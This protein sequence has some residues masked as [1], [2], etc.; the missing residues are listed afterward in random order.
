MKRHYT[1]RL[2]QKAVLEYLKGVYPEWKTFPQILDEIP[3]L[4]VDTFN[5]QS[6]LVKL[7]FKGLISV[8]DSE[9]EEFHR[10]FVYYR[11]KEDT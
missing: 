7:A 9:P 4:N 10:G 2:T 6:V 5:L 8:D 11:F 1:P 3:I